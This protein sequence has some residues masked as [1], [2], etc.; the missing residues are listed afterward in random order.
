VRERERVL[1][2]LVVE[3]T[4]RCEKESMSQVSALGVVCA[5][6]FVFEL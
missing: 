2:M 1:G 4:S 3:V 6:W 5:T